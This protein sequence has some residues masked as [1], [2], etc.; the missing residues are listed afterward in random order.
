M[1]MAGS[2]RQRGRQHG[3]L[4][5]VVGFGMAVGD[6]VELAVACVLVG[7]SSLMA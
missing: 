7:A 1:E 2:G 6:V 4:N 5:I 3:W